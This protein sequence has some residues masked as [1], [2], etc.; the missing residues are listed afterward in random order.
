[1]HSM[2]AHVTNFAIHF[3]ENGRGKVELRLQS[4][5]SSNTNGLVAYAQNFSN[6]RTEFNSV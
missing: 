3:V 4:L 5:Q 1:M 6:C 2:G